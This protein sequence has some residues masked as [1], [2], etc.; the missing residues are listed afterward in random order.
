MI[1]RKSPALG[2]C[3]TIA[4]ALGVAGPVLAEGENTGAGQDGAAAEVTDAQMEKFADAYGAISSVRAEY[5]PKIRQAE[6]KQERT[7]I[8][9]A[10]RQEM[11]AAIQ[12]ADLELAEY[13][14]IGQRIK[15]SPELK[16]R[17]RKL[18]TARRA[19]DGGGA[20]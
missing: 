15:G 16:Q 13:R 18:I 17:F 5:A 12:G 2:A 11:V 8:Q 1:Q 4:L 7:R 6:N 9:K 20:Q 19:E 10:G 3:L 14:Q